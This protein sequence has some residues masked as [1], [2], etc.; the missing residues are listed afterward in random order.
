MS[1][2]IASQRWDVF[3]RHSVYTAES[4]REMILKVRSSFAAAMGKSCCNFLDLH[5][6]TAEVFSV[7]PYTTQTKLAQIAPARQ[8]GVADDEPAAKR[9][10]EMWTE[11]ALLA[12]GSCTG[13]DRSTESV[14]RR[15]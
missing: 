6:S 5:L 7:P 13:T 14:R 4:H 2:I 8:R 15:H 10:C 1:K 11:E 3:L 9:F 12:R